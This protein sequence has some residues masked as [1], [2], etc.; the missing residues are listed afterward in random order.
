MI[1]MNGR[2]A[3]NH[4]SIMGRATRWAG[5]T[6]NRHVFMK[7]GH[8]GNNTKTKIQ[9]TSNFLLHNS[10]KESQQMAD[11][12]QCHRGIPQEPKPF[13]R[14]GSRAP[15]FSPAGRGPGATAL[16]SP[17]G[18]GGSRSGPLPWRGA[19]SRPGAGSFGGINQALVSVKL[20][21]RHPKAG[22]CHASLIINTA[23]D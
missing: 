7:L 21:R 23:A 22:I 19:L 4:T 12:Y 9:S 18:W 10:Q 17:L 8:H 1:R 11:N 5:L 16:L 15:P 13:G 6:A 2:C 3:W 20:G 14:M